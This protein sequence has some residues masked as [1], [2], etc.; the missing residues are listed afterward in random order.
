MGEQVGPGAQ[1]PQMRKSP[2]KN[3]QQVTCSFSI[4]EYLNWFEEEKWDALLTKYTFL[5]AIEDW[6]WKYFV[7]TGFPQ[8]VVVGF[9]SAFCPIIHFSIHWLRQ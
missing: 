8:R 1:N 3:Y 9:P 6:C 2:N 7:K 4:E 5:V